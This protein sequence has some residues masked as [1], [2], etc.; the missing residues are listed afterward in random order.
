MG[1]NVSNVD[2]FLRLKQ[3]SNKDGT[4]AFIVSCNGHRGPLS[5]ASTEEEAMQKARAKFKELGLTGEKA[6]KT[7]KAP[8][9]RATKAA[10]DPS[11]GDLYRA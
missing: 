11:A 2:Q 10:R 9:E 6:E 7:P 1:K 4:A 8:K 5:R 3:V